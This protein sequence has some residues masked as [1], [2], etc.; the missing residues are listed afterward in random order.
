MQTQAFAPLPTRYTLR[1]TPTG[2]FLDSPAQDVQTAPFQP[3]SEW[4]TVRGAIRFWYWTDLRPMFDAF[5][6]VADLG[7]FADRLAVAWLERIHSAARA[8]E[9]VMVEADVDVT[10]VNF[11]VTARG[12]WTHLKVELRYTETASTPVMLVASERAEQAAARLRADGRCAVVTTIDPSVGEEDEEDERIPAAPPPTIKI[13]S[14]GIGN[15]LRFLGGG[16][17]RA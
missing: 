5:E 4:T 17:A 13:T 1:C 11:T 9:P 2:V 10:K 7:E 12:A 3:P 16:E 6:R 14:R 8:A 15:M